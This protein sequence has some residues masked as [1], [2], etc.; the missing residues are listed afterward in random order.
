[1]RAN[2]ALRKASIGGGVKGYEMDRWRGCGGFVLLQVRWSKKGKNLG[3]RE[4]GGGVA[5]VLKPLID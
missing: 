2:S 4:G 3:V 5:A 1:M